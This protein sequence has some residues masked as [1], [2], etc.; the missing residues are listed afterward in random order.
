[1]TT[2][3]ASESLTANS[4]IASDCAPREGILIALWIPTD[5]QGRVRREALAAHINWLKSKGAHGLL[6][7][8]TTGEF[9][10]M[11]VKERETV[12]ELVMEMAAPLPVI[13][14]ISSIRLDEVIHV[15]QAA[16]RLGAA[17]VSVLP[18]W[19]FPLRQDDILQFF[20]QAADRV[21]LPFYLYNYPEVTGNRIGPE[22]IAG[23]ARRARMA[24]FKQSGGEISYHLELVQLGKQFGFSVFTGADPDLARLM[25]QGV[26]GCVSGYGN[27]APEYLI[28]VFNSHKAGRPDAAAVS[29]QR[30][31]K[32]GEIAA[33]MPV[34]FNV[35]SG[36]EARGFDPGEWKSVVSPSTL[37]IYNK[38]LQTFGNVFAEWKL[39]LFKNTVT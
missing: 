14:N 2:P 4:R 12:L 38:G 1:M 33:T 13:A 30:L 36:V 19:F 39:D 5:T 9:S 25:T 20:L 15:G 31:G 24:G 16:K 10:R 21:D 22:A 27:F 35:R 37:E 6:V 3:E 26:R 32:V 7:L 23:F 17:G 18:P 34:P 11:N 8:G 29:S 28:D